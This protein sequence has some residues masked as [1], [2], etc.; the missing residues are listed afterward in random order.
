MSRFRQLNSIAPGEYT[1]TVT[2]FA[3]VGGEEFHRIAESVGVKVESKW[4]YVYLFDGE[5][6]VK[7]SRTRNE[8]AQVYLDMTSA[9]MMR[10]KIINRVENSSQCCWGKFGWV[11]SCGGE[12]SLW[13]PRTKRCKLHTAKWLKEEIAQDLHSY[14]TPEHW[15]EVAA[16]AEADAAAKEAARPLIEAAATAAREQAKAEGFAEWKKIGSGWCISV[17]DHQVGDVVSVRTRS[18]EVTKHTLGESVGAG[19]YKSVGEYKN[20]A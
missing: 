4:V 20:A 6:V 17:A 7:L 9:E 15:P 11:R 1:A 14:V 19:I 3:S 5:E 8:S 2:W 13:E 12:E 10:E 16:Q 18:G